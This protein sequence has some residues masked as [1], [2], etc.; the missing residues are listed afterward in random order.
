MT[1]GI[2]IYLDSGFEG[3]AKGKADL[4]LL[5]KALQKWLVYSVE[6]STSTL[7]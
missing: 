3:S 7:E 5:K 4:E 2:C 1:G 6:M